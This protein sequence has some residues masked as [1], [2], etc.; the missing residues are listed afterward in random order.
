MPKN[1][2]LLSARILIVDD[3]EINL[4]LLEVLLRREGFTHIHSTTDPYSVLPA[5]VTYQP[6]II[7]LDLLMPGMDGFA[8]IE[9]LRRRIP[10]GAFLPILVLTADVTP[11]TRRRALALGAKD[12]L[13][14]PFDSIEVMLR[15]WNLLETRFF[16]LQLQDQNQHLGRQVE[17]GLRDIDA[18]QTEVIWRLTQA[19]EFRDEETGMHTQRVGRLAALIA[20]AMD[21]DA[22]M[23]ELIRQAAPLHDV[24]KIA[25]PDQILLKPSRLSAAEVEQMKQH[26]TIGARMLVGSALPLLQMAHD[27]ALSHHEHWDGT[28]YPHGVQ[29]TAIPLAARIVAVADSI[30][31]L[32]HKRPYKQAWSVEQALAEITA[33]SGTHYDPQVVDALVQVLLQD[34]QLQPEQLLAQ[35]YGT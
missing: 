15:I 25:I 14:K 28:G 35:T 30:D 27:I 24:G 9:L 29:G 1:E 11:E 7:L 17:R 4:R 33:G 26:T 23:V 8:L 3:Q 16:Y 21:L 19:A 32:T 10:A 13:T 18:A 20:Q 5:Y 22:D 6:D 2:H 31:A 12:F 34:K